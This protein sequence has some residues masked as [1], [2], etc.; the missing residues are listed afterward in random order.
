MKTMTL[1]KNQE[2]MNCYKKKILKLYN[3]IKKKKKNIQVI[4]KLIT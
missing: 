2:K 4:K 1:K 3:E